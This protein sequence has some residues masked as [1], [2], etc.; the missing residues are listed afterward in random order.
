LTIPTPQ[1]ESLDL[2][3]WDLTDAEFRAEIPAFVG[4]IKSIFETWQLAEFLGR[5]RESEP[6]DPSLPTRSSRHEPGIVPDGFHAVVHRKFVANADPFLAG[7]AHE[8]EREPAATEGFD[9]CKFR[10]EGG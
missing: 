3:Y 1:G 5:A 2:S 10:L 6:F 7:I 9:P 8:V 4:E